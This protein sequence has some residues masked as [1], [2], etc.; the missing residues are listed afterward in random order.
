MLARDTSHP[1]SVAIALDYLAMLHQFQRDAQTALE[2][3][4]EAR[5]ICSEHGF[6]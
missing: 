5:D 1:F 3:A 6:D 4:T 2:V